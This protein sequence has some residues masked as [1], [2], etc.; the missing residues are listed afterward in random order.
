VRLA[1]HDWSFRDGL[2]EMSNFYCLPGRAGGSLIGLDFATAYWCSLIN[3]AAMKRHFPASPVGCSTGCSIANPAGCRWSTR[4]LMNTFNAKIKTVI[5]GDVVQT[6]AAHPS[7]QLGT[8]ASATAHRGRRI[9]QKRAYGTQCLV[10]CPHST[11]GNW[12]QP[13]TPACRR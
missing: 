12:Q 7:A 8:N 2:L 4:M 11:W 13:P 10:S 5:A 3:C 6:I 9:S 1:A